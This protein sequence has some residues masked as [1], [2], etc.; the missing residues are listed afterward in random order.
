MHLRLV[1]L[2]FALLCS[3]VLVE[4][5]AKSQAALPIPLLQPSFVFLLGRK[6][7]SGMVQRMD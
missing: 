6:R 5:F 7:V 1:V 4:S 2:F 3:S